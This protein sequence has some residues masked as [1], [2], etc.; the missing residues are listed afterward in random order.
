MSDLISVIIPTFNRSK[1]ILDAVES[2]INQTY[3]NVEIIVVDDGS[4]DETY[5]ILKPYLHRLKYVYQDNMG[6]SS[7]R[8]KGIQLSN[9]NY[10]AFLD[11]D[12]LFLPDKLTFQKHLLDNNPRYSLAYTNIYF[13]DYRSKHMKIAF[14]A[15]MFK[16]GSL[17]E[18]VLL[19]KVMTGYLQTWLVKKQC[20]E[21]I[22]L[23]DSEFKMSE[24][25]D[26]SI[27]MALYFEMI[28]TARPLT[29]LRHHDG[30]RLG[31]SDASERE[32]YYFK[33]LNKL[34]SQHGNHPLL[35]KNK[36]YIYSDYYQLAGKAYMRNVK[37]K[38]ARTRFKNSFLKNPRRI[39]SLIYYISTF[40]GS[41]VIQLLKRMRNSIHK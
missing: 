30:T 15:N 21:Q 13:S 17:F 1:Y 9:G 32:Y 4:T 5:S 16:S 27:R 20:F 25:R 31:R 26:I 34:Y 38:E 3:S 33:F 18:D 6:V 19:R 28:G 36:R 23:I 11:S 2:V 41:P 22:G 24:D 8:N 14:K 7:A 37:Y 40:L 29:V 10:I 39:S 35:I 12:D